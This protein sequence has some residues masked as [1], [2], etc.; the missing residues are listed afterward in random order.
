MNIE[1]LSAKVTNNLFDRSGPLFCVVFSLLGCV[2]TQ[3]AR[4]YTFHR[5]NS[6]VEYLILF[7]LVQKVYFKYRSRN[8]TVIVK[9]KLVRFSLL[10]AY[11]VLSVSNGL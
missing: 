11:C 6:F 9:N 2:E 5:P 3:L 1:R 10:T 7:P 4:S 8:M